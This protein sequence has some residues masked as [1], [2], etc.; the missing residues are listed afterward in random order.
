MKYYAE[1]AVSSF[2]YYMWNAW[3]K[4]ECK[5]V[6]GGDYLH[7][8][9]KWNA[10]AENSIHGAAERFYAELSECNRTLLVERAVS[11]YDGRAKREKTQDEDI[12]V[13]NVCGSVLYEI[14]RWVNIDTGESICEFNNDNVDIEEWCTECDEFLSSYTMKDF[15]EKMQSWWDSCDFKIMEQITG[16][17]ET[18]YPSDNGSQAFVDAAAQWW[19]SQN[20]ERKR[21]LYN[22]YNFENE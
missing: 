21:K 14:I 5:V 13:C 18:D 22:E 12:Y 3:S 1:N 2:F 20:Y 15:K 11:L 8:W 19:N 16:L 9:E 17:K 4:E 7:F 10:Q 6:F